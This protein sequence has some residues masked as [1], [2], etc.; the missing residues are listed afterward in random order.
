MMQWLIAAVGYG[1][2]HAFHVTA[3]TLE[4]PVQILARRVFYRTGTA[5]SPLFRSDS[6]DMIGNVWEWLIYNSM[7]RLNNRRILLERDH[8]GWS[9]NYRLPS[10][11]EWE[12]TGAPD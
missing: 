9:M 1:F 10:E 7:N 5:R 4:Q 11:A 3:R 6:D 2:R 8:R 12:Y